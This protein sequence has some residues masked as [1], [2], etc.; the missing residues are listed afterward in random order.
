M[1]YQSAVS[2]T[3]GLGNSKN[4]QYGRGSW[5]TMHETGD[6]LLCP[7]EALCCILRARKDLGWQNNVHLCADIDVSEVVQ[8]LKMVAAKI[9]VPASNYSSHSVRIGGATSLL[10]GDADGLQIK[11]LGRW[12]SNCFEGYPVLAFAKTLAEDTLSQT[13]E[14]RQAFNSDGATHH[15]PVLGH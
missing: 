8:A 12:L 10:S 11:L 7:K 6:S 13:S 15:V 1:R 4:D 9:G 5:R 14:T 3:I 2:V